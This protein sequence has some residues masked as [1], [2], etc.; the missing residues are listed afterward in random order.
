MKKSFIYLFLIIAFVFLLW[1]CNNNGNINESNLDK[2]ETDI[3]EDEE[4]VIEPCIHEYVDGVCV[5]CNE[6]CEHDYK[7]G[8]CIICGYEC[9]HEEIKYG[10]CTECGIN[11]QLI[12][13]HVYENGKCTI[14]DYG[15]SHDHYTDGICDE[16]DYHCE[17]SI[18]EKG[19]CTKCGINYQLI[20]EHTYKNGKCLICDY[21]CPH[22]H[23][24][25]GIC[26]EC[27]IR[28]NHEIIVD[29]YCTICGI[30]YQDVCNHEFVD[31]KCIICNYVCKHEKAEC[32]E[33]CDDCGKLITHKLLGGKCTMCDYQINFTDSEIP[34]IYLADCPNKGTVEK[35]VWQSYDYK[36]K[37]RYE[38]TFFAYLPYGYDPNS[39]KEYNVLYLLHG[40]GEN[41]AYWLAQLT[42]KGS[43]TEK[44]KIVLDNMHYYGLC[45]DTIVITPTSNLNGTANFYKE[46]LD[47]IMPLAETKY[48]TKAHLY[49]KN[50]EDIKDEDFI[51][52][53]Q[54]RAYAGLSLGSMIGWSILAY[55]L[56]YFGYY[57]FYSGGS[58]GLTQYYNDS[59][60]TVANSE[61]KVLYAYHSC[62]ND[63]MYSNHLEEYNGLLKAS[64]GKL[65]PGQ[66]TNFLYKAKFGHEYAAWIIDLYNSLGYVFFK[67]EK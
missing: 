56:P 22:E 58:Y 34:S 7:K 64:N 14:C 8:K 31:G 35:T 51:S 16:C 60:T 53:R 39:D 42:Y 38:N 12:C 21:V 24:T 18:I 54:Y 48:K 50:V 65:L 37:R 61:Y 43:R 46:L 9:K 44:T 47:E 49:G 10:Y 66:N 5:K 15:C 26:D 28:C 19:I 62:G 30:N 33:H 45:E 32:G 25:R 63:S 3:K 36:N 17:H 57:G 4:P 11:Y 6:Q 20:C 27:R 23:Y 13:N 52:S 41:S 2:E 67:F 40:S 59:K 55:E 1:G 29:G